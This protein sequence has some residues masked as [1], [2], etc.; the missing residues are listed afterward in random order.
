M[1]V[2]VDSQILAVA[3]AHSGTTGTTTAVALALEAARADQSVLLIDLSLDGDATKWLGAT[4]WEK[5]QHVG[6]IFADRYPVGWARELAVPTRSSPNLWVVP[7]ADKHPRRARRVMGG[8]LRIA[9][10]T[11]DD[12]DVV[13]IDCGPGHSDGR[14]T[15]A[16]IA[17]TDLIVVSSARD[18]NLTEV[19][20]VIETL[21]CFRR[22]AILRGIDETTLVRLRGIVVEDHSGRTGRHWLAR[23]TGPTGETWPEHVLTPV[24]PAGTIRAPQSG[25]WS[26]KE[27]APGGELSTLYAQ[28]AAQVIDGLAASD[29]RDMPLNSPRAEG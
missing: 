11:V 26:E 18:E 1:H 15:S 16:L 6:S 14:L 22:S 9:L 4:P 10:T 23:M 28:L 19:T 3:H 27:W 7:A 20:H 5:G 24:L 12:F 21:D 25:E 13:V 2:T 29:S 8:Q 17:A